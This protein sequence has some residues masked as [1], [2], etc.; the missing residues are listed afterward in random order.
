[1]RILLIILLLVVIYLGYKWYMYNSCKNEEFSV[2]RKDMTEARDSTAMLH[3]T[4]SFWKGKVCRKLTTEEVVG[5]AT[6]GR[7]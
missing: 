2:C 1:M 7:G 4:C 3:I 5:I 6:A